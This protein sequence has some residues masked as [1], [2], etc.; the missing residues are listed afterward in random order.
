MASRREK[1]R[2]RSQ[3]EQQ[4]EQTGEQ[5]GKRAC[6]ILQGTAA[7]SFVKH[8]HARTHRSAL[9]HALPSRAARTGRQGGLMQLV[10][11]LRP[12][13]MHAPSPNFNVVRV[14]RT[15]RSIRMQK[16]VD[17]FR[18]QRTYRSIRMQKIVDKF[19]I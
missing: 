6:A 7:R 1:D 8:A 2:Q 17:K 3:H 10:D 5:D 13:E 14:Q 9:A 15:Y 16:I 12:S 4:H 18:V 11:R 19:R